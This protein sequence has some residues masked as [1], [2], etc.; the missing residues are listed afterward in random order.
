[1]T[2]A[3]SASIAIVGAT[4]GIE[5]MLTSCRVFNASQLLLEG[6]GGGAAEPMFFGVVV[7]GRAAISTAPGGGA[8]C[9]NVICTSRSSRGPLDGSVASA[10]V[11]SA[12]SDV[13]NA[14]VAK[15][16]MP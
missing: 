11:K 9:V 12:V 10:S 4:C 16:L 7:P 14:F 5:T 15:R 2:A 6:G 3:S 1:M 13:L 8:P